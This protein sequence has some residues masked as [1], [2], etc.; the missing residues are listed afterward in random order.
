MPAAKVQIMKVL[1]KL[2]DPDI[3]ID[4]LTEDISKDVTLS[5]RLLRYLNSAHF[6]LPQEVDSIRQAIMMLG[7]NN[8][9][10]IATLIVM[11]RIDDKPSDLFKTGLIRAKMCGL[12]ADKLQPGTADMFFT[13][14]L[15]SIIDAMM[16]TPIQDIIHRLP[17]GKELQQALLFQEGLVGQVLGNVIK[18]VGGKPTV[19][20]APNISQDELNKIYLRALQWADAATAELSS[21]A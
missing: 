10:S 13:A 9:R 1:A 12:L 8:I 17:L 19:G 4:E 18:F 3:G 16:D 14:G 6:S 7:W 15:F 11:S 20:C 5:Y 21:A 2:H